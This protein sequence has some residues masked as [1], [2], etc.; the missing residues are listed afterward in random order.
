[1]S[2][3]PQQMEA[4][5]R[6]LN[7]AMDRYATIKAI[8]CVACTYYNASEMA[9]VGLEHLLLAD[10]IK[11]ESSE[12]PQPKLFDEFSSALG[13]KPEKPMEPPRAKD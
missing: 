3:T 9:I 1:M 10:A 2:L 5:I 4:T 12:L 11:N 13:K 8:D 6:T 7:A